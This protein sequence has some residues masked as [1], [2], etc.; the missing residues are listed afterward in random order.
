MNKICLLLT[1][2]GLAL[3]N[4]GD[5]SAED[6]KATVDPSGIWRWEHEQNGEVIKDVLKLTFDDSKL[7]GS[8][9]GR[10]G[11]YKIKNGKVAENKISFE[12]NAEV[13]ETE[14]FVKFEG[15][16][17]GDEVNGSVHAEF[18]G[19]SETFPWTA[20]RGL[21]NEDVVG[22]WKLEVETSEGDIIEPVLTLKVEDGSIVGKIEIP[23]RYLELEVSEIKVKD[24]KLYLTIS[25][26]LDGRTLTSKYT[27]KPQGDKVS[28]KIAYDFDGET[29]ELEVVGK[30]K[31]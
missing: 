15:E 8:Y 21:K 13:N 17:K 30:R 7:T 19:E 31:S 4:A 5:L 10:I 27:L 26:D 1:F 23:D 16:I 11:P 3:I 18:D 2:C 25:G 24:Q 9:E 28:G 22:K 6:A 12:F 14:V 29:G 20:E